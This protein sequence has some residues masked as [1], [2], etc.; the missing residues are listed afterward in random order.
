MNT[1]MQ[2]CVFVWLV[3][4]IEWVGGCGWAGSWSGGWV[5]AAVPVFYPFALLMLCD[6]AAGFYISLMP[7]KLEKHPTMAS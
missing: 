1:K 2:L 5:T 6:A 3:L 7:R 4:G